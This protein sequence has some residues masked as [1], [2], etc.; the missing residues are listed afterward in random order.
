MLTES[1]LGATS[2]I[3]SP[4]SSTIARS[5]TRIAIEAQEKEGWVEWLRALAL[6]VFIAVPILGFTGQTL[7]GRIVW[8]CVVASL[9]L[10]IVLVGYHRWR[11]ICPLA[12]FGKLPAKLGIGGHRTVP[13]WLENHY[14][15]IALSFFVFGL[16][17]RH[18]AINGDGPVLGLFFIFIAGCA[19]LVGARYTGKS[20]C[21]FIC[22]LVFIEKIYTEPHGLRE[23]ANSQC[24]KCT[25]CKK[26]CPDINQENGY[27]KEL[28]SPSKKVAY[29]AFPGLVFGFYLYYYLQSG[30]WH[31]YF[32]GKWV[33]E[34]GIWRTAF[35]PGT[36]ADTAG[37]FFWPQIPRAAAALITLLACGLASYIL[38]SML[39]NP[40]R[41]I[42]KR[43]KMKSDRVQR[44]HILFS[45][46]GFCAF[47][48]FYSYAGQPTLRLFQPSPHFF[49]L[50]VVLTAAI[51]LVR[52]MTRDQRAFAE[53]SLARNIVKRWEWPDPAPANLREAFLVHTIRAKESKKSA[54]RSLEIYKDALREALA[55]G[56]V[57]REEVHRLHALRDQLQI[58]KSD[59][60]KVMAALDEEARELL[61]DPTKQMSA[62]KRL[63]LE[64]YAHALENY[65]NLAFAP[66]GKA[67][68]AIVAQLRDEYR[69]TP[70]EH[71]R[72]LEDLLGGERGVGTRLSEALASIERAAHT[73]V[74][75]EKDPNPAHDFLRDILERRRARSANLLVKSLTLREDEQR[76]LAAGLAS[77]DPTR[78][79]TAVVHLRQSVMPALA[80]R[81][82]DAQRRTSS[83]E[84][85]LKTLREKLIQRTHS[86]D[87]YERALSVYITASMS[88]AGEQEFKHVAA[89]A[90]DV[91]RDTIVL[92][93]NKFSS[94]R[95]PGVGGTSGVIPLTGQSGIQRVPGGTSGAM[96]L[97]SA[98]LPGIAPALPLA[99]V[100]KM[101][102]LRSA[103]IFSRLEPESLERLAK[104]SVEAAYPAGAAL[105]IDGENGSEVFILVE[106]DVE[107]VKGEG[108][109]RKVLAR[110][111]AG[112]F[113]GELAVI[114]PAPRSATVLA[115]PAGVR[116]L[117]LDGTAFREALHHDASIA[118]EVMRTLAQRLKQRNG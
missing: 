88:D 66:D 97:S 5:G 9:P 92:V 33:N 115:G 71:R 15:L 105:C 21:N 57:T 23:T 89:D 95:L 73:I 111:K 90:H 77:N 41:W 84:A 116:V 94:S 16:W 50:V 26:F 91:V 87:P 114:D 32:G 83:V 47:V 76:E 104:A 45:V 68:E 65:L 103:P 49:L 31:Y 112:G 61:N 39:R 117:K 109:A 1:A 102:A 46:A 69:V 30:T 19:F 4:A 44:R 64:T 35:F 13:A 62:E 7:A 10:F 18:V 75:L 72:V 29:L 53:E 63:Q 67:N 106:G 60:D 3:R 101:I 54:E 6:A 113:I 107:I 34:P 110:E 24:S 2:I 28:R 52:R 22:P 98:R 25:A 20:W 17:M 40:I 37:F 93:R 38:F 108:A 51:Y 48:C 27:W 79:E 56:T 100:E 82:L 86:A 43:S 42:L 55:E 96:S 99:S 80:E 74:A 12:A 58:K 59:H 14:H 11:R 8:T 36:N 70:E 85:A 118:D 81:L 78:R